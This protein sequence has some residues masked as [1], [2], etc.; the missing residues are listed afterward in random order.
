MTSKLREKEPFIANAII[1]CLR[2]WKERCHPG[3]M[4]V[5]EEDVEQLAQ[6]AAELNASW[7]WVKEFNIE[8]GFPYRI[9]PKQIHTRRHQ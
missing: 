8:H 1:R 6:W 5:T 4:I 3:P 7:E 2:T 9:V